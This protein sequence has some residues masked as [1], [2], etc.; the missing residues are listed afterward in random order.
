MDIQAYITAPVPR[1]L[2]MSAIVFTAIGTTASTYFIMKKRYDDLFDLAVANEVENTEKFLSSIS[3]KQYAS[4]MDAAQSIIM[5]EVTEIIEEEEY[6]TDDEN[7]DRIEIVENVWTDALDYEI[8]ED[9]EEAKR[10]RGK[11][12]IIKHDEFFHSDNQMVTLTWFEG[13]EVLA[14]EKDEHIPDIERVIGEDNLLRFGYGSGDP[15]ILYIRNEK[16]EIDFEIVKND[17]KYTEQ[18]LG[19]IQHNVGGDRKRVLRMR[20]YDDD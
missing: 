3:T 6:V 15:N 9:A 4:P 10:K 13:D 16:M 8:D 5:T 19:F 20:D 17:G 14:D 1:W 18:V 12:F 2:A 7:G 11:P